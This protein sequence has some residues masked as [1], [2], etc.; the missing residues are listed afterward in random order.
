MITL[1]SVAQRRQD[2]SLEGGGVTFDI[3]T[4]VGRRN[5]PLLTIAARQLAQ[6]VSD[7]GC[8]LCAQ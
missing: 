3:A 6:G 5:E 2:R 8:D 7:A 1:M 4:M